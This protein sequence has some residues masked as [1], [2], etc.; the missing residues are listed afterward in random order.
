MFVNG[1]AVGFV[2]KLLAVGLPL[3]C[4]T[5]AAHVVWVVRLSRS[6]TLQNLGP[7]RRS[8][9]LAFAA[10]APVVGFHAVE[11][12]R[13]S[14]RSPPSAGRSRAAALLGVLGPFLAAVF[15]LLVAVEAR[16]RLPGVDWPG[17]PVRFRGMLV[18][19]AVPYAVLVMAGRV[20]ARWTATR[21]GWVAGAATAMIC[22]FLFA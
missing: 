16:R 19:C 3:L 2:L 14:R 9:A 1:D 18:V 8:V 13:W 6:P 17:L 21:A 15:G 7:A 20:L 22:A 11:G 5:L 4:L 12:A 10:A